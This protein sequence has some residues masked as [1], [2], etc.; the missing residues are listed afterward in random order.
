[1]REAVREFQSLLAFLFGIDGVLRSLIERQHLAEKLSG[2]SLAGGDHQHQ[3]VRRVERL[4][5]SQCTQRG[6]LAGLPGAQHEQLL[7]G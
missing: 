3:A 1:M 7:G 4:V 5:Q 2:L 6:G